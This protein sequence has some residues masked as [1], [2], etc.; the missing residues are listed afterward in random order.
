MA[1][2]I[3]QTNATLIRNTV[4]WLMWLAMAFLVFVQFKKF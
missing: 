1:R 2:A 4:T 3:G